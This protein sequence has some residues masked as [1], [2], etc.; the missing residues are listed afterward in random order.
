MW[1]TKNLTHFYLFIKWT[2]LFITALVTDINM[3]KVCI[4]FISI[5]VPVFLYKGCAGFHQGL[6]QF[7]SR[8][9]PVFIKDCAGFCIGLCHF[10]SRI[11]PVFYQWFSASFFTMIVPVLSTILQTIHNSQVYQYLMTERHD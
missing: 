8:V 9:V 3:L 10:W 5:I 7:L 2:F 11:V 4:S 1:G 6:C